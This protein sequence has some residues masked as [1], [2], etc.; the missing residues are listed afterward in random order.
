MGGFRFLS[1]KEFEDNERFFKYCPVE[2]YVTDYAYLE[3]GLFYRN[4]K[5]NQFGGQWWLNKY[6]HSNG[7]VLVV[8]TLGGLLVSHYSGS[9]GARPV[10]DYSLIGR[11]CKMVDELDL[12]I[13]EVECGEYP[14]KIVTE[15]LAKE[16]ETEQFLGY[17]KKTGKTYTMFVAEDLSQLWLFHSF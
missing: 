16:L 3:G 12:G 4:P 1:K 11:Y 2:A 5:Y 7:K 6:N 10:I 15:E 8:T 14:K 9:F 13:I 17:L